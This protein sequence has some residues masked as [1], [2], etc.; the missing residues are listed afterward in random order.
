MKL[1][2]RSAGKPC[3][4]AFSTSSEVYGNTYLNQYNPGESKI[5]RR[6]SSSSSIPKSKHNWSNST[7]AKYDG[8]M[9]VAHMTVYQIS[10]HY[11]LSQG[12]GKDPLYPQRQLASSRRV[13]SGRFLMSEIAVR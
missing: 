9:G 13:R 3:L 6:T 12:A 1:T 5:G 4:T 2:G 11:T 7:V 10:A 8:L